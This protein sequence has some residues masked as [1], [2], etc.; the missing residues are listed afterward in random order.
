MTVQSVSILRP[1]STVKLGI[2]TYQNYLFPWLYIDSKL[3][4]NCS[5]G[6]LIHVSPVL[7]GTATDEQEMVTALYNFTI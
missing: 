3:Q 1:P 6:S 7:A 4:F 2:G 5:S